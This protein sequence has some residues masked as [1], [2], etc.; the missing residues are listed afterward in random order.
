MHILLDSPVLDEARAI[1]VPPRRAAPVTLLDTQEPSDDPSG[2]PRRAA[3]ISPVAVRARG[4]DYDPA[5]AP[6]RAAVVVDDRRPVF[7]DD[8][9]HRATFLR[10]AGWGFCLI[11]VLLCAA[12]GLTL[13]AHV[14]VP[15]LDGLFGSNA[16][17]KPT[18]ASD[19]SAAG[20]ADP[21]ELGGVGS[22]RLP[23]TGQPLQRA[24]RTPSAVTT[25]DSRPT[26]GMSSGS[27]TAPLLVSASPLAMVAV[28]GSPATSATSAAALGKTK[29]RNPH[30]A[31][32]TPG[33]GH[34]RPSGGS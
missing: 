34:D 18:P 29:P 3:E 17:R 30:A 19:R 1:G 21:T 31:T 23:A 13:A 8:S 14:S 2:A 28:P 6:R 33:G 25:A 11:G 15:G 27:S 4:E 26:G 32:P 24:E 20:A 16:T 5:I 22:D 7:S 9:G 12:L 10:W